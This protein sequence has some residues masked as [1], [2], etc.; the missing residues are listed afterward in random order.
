MQETV[1]VVLDAPGD[2]GVGAG[3]QWKFVEPFGNDSRFR[4]EPP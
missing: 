2:H 4:P 3:D 1:D